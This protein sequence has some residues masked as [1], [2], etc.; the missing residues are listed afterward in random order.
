MSLVFEALQNLEA[1]RYGVFRATPPEALE[2]LRCVGERRAA[3]QPEALPQGPDV[4]VQVAEPAKLFPVPS[5]VAASAAVVA[6]V[7][8]PAAV[9]ITEAPVAGVATAAAEAA[10]AVPVSA[11]AA[12]TVQTSAVEEKPA[13]AA[14]PVQTARVQVQAAPRQ[15]ATKLGRA[16]AMVS[17]ALPMVQSVLNLI[18]GNKGSAAA[19]APEAK[20]QTAIAVPA[21]SQVDLTVITNG[22]TALKMQQRELH[23]Q[24]V[25][26]NATLKQIEGHLEMVR[27]A[28]HR[29]TQEQKELIEDL[30]SVGSKINFVAVVGLT[31]LAASVGIDLLLYL[32][33]IKVF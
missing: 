8:A 30:K 21:K 16:V 1:E 4:D 5:P 2:L 33:M 23:A 26:Q 17:A 14:A 31:L 22:L 12:S 9:T 10:S 3:A 6:D 15:A 11:V 20:P 13:V 7:V 28:T 19:K 29:N 18:D 24:V 25:E 32:H 27:E